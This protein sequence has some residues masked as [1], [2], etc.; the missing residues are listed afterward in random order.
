QGVRIQFT[1]AEYFP[2]P[3]RLPL[4]IAG[5]SRQ[6]ARRVAL[7]AQGWL[8]GGMTPGEYGAGLAALD[9]EMAQH[10]R[11]V[12]DLERGIEIFTAV[13]ASGAAALE[14][15]QASLQHQWG[16]VQR[17][18]DRSLVG[19]ADTVR[20]RIAAYAKAGVTHFEIKFICH[21][22]SMMRQM[23]E[24]YARQIVPSVH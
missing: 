2:K 13:A 3:R 9:A 14:I 19:G 17:G 22:L 18:L 12:M 11:T 7:Y 23:I 24:D 6:A 15:A 10:G 16:D 1:G 21:D 8:P 20:R 4:W 5:M